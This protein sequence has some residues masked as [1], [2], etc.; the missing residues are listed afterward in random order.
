M[1]AVV[2]TVGPSYRVLV[3]FIRL[4][5]NTFFRR[6]EVV[7]REHV[8]A[9]GAVIFAGN[10]PNALM[11]GFVV[12]TM[13]GRRPVHFMANAKLRRYPLMSTFLDTLGAVPV[14]LR[15]EHPDAASNEAAFARLFEVLEAGSCMGIFPEGIS[16][17]GSQLVR[18]KTGT[19]R[20]AL[21]VAARRKVGVTLVPCGLTYTHRH[22]FRSQ[23]LLH[24]GEPI[25]VD[26]EWL[27]AY[28]TSEVDTVHA[29]TDHVAGELAKVTLNAPD[30]ETLRFIHTVRRLYKPASVHLTPGTYVELS[31]RFV[32][33]YLATAAD[34]DIQRL[35]GDVEDYQGHLDLLGLQDHHLRESLGVLEAWKGVLWRSVAVIALLPLAIPGALIH[36][37][38][39]WVAMTAGERLS[40]D[41][42]D[43]A[44]LKVITSVLL[45]P[46]VYIGA[47]AVVGLNFGLWW[48]AAVTTVLPLSFLAFIK[49][50]EVQANMTLA[51]LTNLKL[52]RFSQEVEE[53][54]ETRSRLVD[55]VRA[56]ADTHA[57][58]SLPRVFSRDDLN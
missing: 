12:A 30:W 16:H 19:A 13:C 9:E 15:A 26:E 51:T 57:D 37:P 54:R 28:A 18:L 41:R 24:F 10:H 50:V 44:T 27:E 55:R 21:A 49:V 39:G 36:L 6:I 5:V 56:V 8:P 42:D 33:R 47:G 34:P 31:R 25:V 52:S 22:R 48:G 40:D 23:A 35:R 29:F 43:V 1:S 53:L 2:G 4:V 58:P 14:Y 20:I 11:D 3:W 7:G 38:V 17:T 46:F 32:E 45:L